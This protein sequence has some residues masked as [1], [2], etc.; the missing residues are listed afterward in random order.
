MRKH[1]VADGD[2]CCLEMAKLA[3]IAGADDKKF[4]NAFHYEVVAMQK[5]ASDAFSEMA[6][7]FFDRL[8]IWFGK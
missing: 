7:L 8:Q 3:A 4:I 5:W 1:Q 6:V 2:V